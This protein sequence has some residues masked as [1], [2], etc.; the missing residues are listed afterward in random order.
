MEKYIYLI[1]EYLIYANNLLNIDLSL[2]FSNSKNL[3][4][5]IKGIEYS[6]NTNT[7]KKA[8]SV[9]SFNVLLDNE[10]I[11]K[12]NELITKYKDLR[13][14]FL[15][16][17]LILDENNKFKSAFVGY[18]NIKKVSYENNFYNIELELKNGLKIIKQQ[19]LKYLFNNSKEQQIVSNILN[20]NKLKSLPLHYKKAIVLH[21]NNEISANEIYNSQI[22]SKIERQASQSAQNISSKYIIIIYILSDGFSFKAD[23]I[24]NDNQNFYIIKTKGENIEDY[25]TTLLQIARLQK[26]QNITNK[27][28]KQI[29]YNSVLNDLYIMEKDGGVVKKQQFNNIIDTQDSETNN[30]V[31]C[32]VIVNTP[33][34]K[35]YNY[36]YGLKTFNNL[37]IK[38]D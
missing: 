26:E 33:T 38:G 35:T 17:D 34:K 10:E 21:T 13:L 30:I 3:I 12:I 20:Y 15:Y 31:I 36:I 37:E 4:N 5:N 11:N 24:K 7:E 25:Y 29:V 27:T 2:S 22:I 1:P 9:V 32:S 14:Y 8:N 16:S 23:Y 18:G 19:A 6:N 28:D